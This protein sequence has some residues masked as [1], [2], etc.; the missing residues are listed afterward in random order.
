MNL[1]NKYPVRVE[2]LEQRMG[3]LANRTAKACRIKDKKGMIYY[4]LKLGYKNHV[5]TKAVQYECLVL[6]KGGYKLFVYSPSPD[7]Y[8]PMRVDVESAVLKA[9]DEDLRMFLVESVIDAYT[10]WN[11]QTWIQKWMPLIAPILVAIAIAIVL[12]SAGDMLQS[13]SQIMSSSLDVAQ[14]IKGVQ[15]IPVG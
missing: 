1:F 8:I 7:Q 13:G 3:T 4:D 6:C 9:I 14:K 10:R 5:K 15:I 2:I 12:F 11:E